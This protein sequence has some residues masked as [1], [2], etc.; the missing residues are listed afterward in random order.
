M[1]EGSD[2][3]FEFYRIAPAS[4]FPVGE[5][6]FLEIGGLPIVVFELAGEF[7]ATRD[8]CS[9]DGGAIGDGELIGEEIICPRHGARFNLRTGKA[10]SLPAVEGIPVY[11]VRIVEGYLE[12]GLP[13]TTKTS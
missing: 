6:L 13:L 7:I 8:L 11:P 9:H 4:E 10:V 1:S 2:T 3:G 12:I 5:R